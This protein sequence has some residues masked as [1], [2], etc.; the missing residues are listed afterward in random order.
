L[1]CLVSTH[2]FTGVSAQADS[3][4]SHELQFIQEVRNR[5]DDSSGNSSLHST[6][7]YI[8][9]GEKCIYG[10]L[11][12]GKYGF[13]AAMGVT[14]GGIIL[15]LIVIYFDIP[16]N[17][18]IK[19]IKPYSGSERKE[20]LRSILNINTHMFS[21]L[22]VPCET[23]SLKC[24]V[25]VPHYGSTLSSNSLSIECSHPADHNDCSVSCVI[26]L[27]QIE[28]DQQII[29]TNKCSH[30]FHRGCIAEWLIKENTCP[31]C[32]VVMVTDE[33]IVAAV[34]AN[35]GD[36]NIRSPNGD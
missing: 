35:K 33:E 29:S 3:T 15:L 5:L 23:K 26:C 25:I 13:F 30:I 8:C 16:I 2:A 22:E 12:G 6:V 19:K 36:D 7:D 14:I 4:Y 24:E 10:K 1:Y 31:C 28:G 21:D 34:K 27:G 17:E 9:T 32:R 20:A 18:S 11:G